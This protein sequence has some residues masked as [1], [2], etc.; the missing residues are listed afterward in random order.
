MELCCLQKVRWRGASARTIVGK[1]SR[2][3]LFWTGCENGKGGVGNVLAEEWVEKAS[4]GY[5]I[6]L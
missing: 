5:L 6:V 3:K 2:Y 4:V 1:N